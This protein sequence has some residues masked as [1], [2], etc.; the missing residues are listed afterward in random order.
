MNTT[1]LLILSTVV[2]APACAAGINFNLGDFVKAISDQAQ[3][4]TQTSSSGGGQAATQPNKKPSNYIGFLPNGWADKEYAPE[5]L[6]G[7]F[8]LRIGS[9]GK[10]LNSP[11]VGPSSCDMAYLYYSKSGK[12]QMGDGEL[13]YCALQ[14]FFIYKLTTDD[15]RNLNDGF[16]KQDTINEFSKVALKRFDEIKKQDNYYIRAAAVKIDP[17][18]FKTKSFPIHVNMMG[19]LTDEPSKRMPYNFI[20]NGF[21]SATGN[22]LLIN[23]SADSVL[24]KELEAA[25]VKP[26]S[27]IDGMNEVH[28]KVK[29]TIDATRGPGDSGRNVEI[30]VT[31]FVT[32]FVTTDGKIA[33]IGF[34]F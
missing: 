29:K 21:K 6:G 30:E 13:E 19:G 18:N 12:A 14:E 11:H 25:R 1:A 24:A 7:S 28:F 16:V 3:Q 2:S 23:L 17:Y 20:G 31:K 32:S 10:Y 22:W 27:L 9:N 4:P 15:N 5:I 8:H 34:G 33:D 26:G